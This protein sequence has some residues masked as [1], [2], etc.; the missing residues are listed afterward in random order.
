MIFLHEICISV[1]KEYTITTLVLQFCTATK[2]EK[3][4]P[5]GTK[6]ETLCLFS[7]IVIS[8]TLTVDASVI[9]LLIYS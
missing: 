9:R 8:T 4:N 1:C 2:I 6:N 7:R 5:A 3:K